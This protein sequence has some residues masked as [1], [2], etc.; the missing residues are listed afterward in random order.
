MKLALRS[1][2]PEYN[3]ILKDYKHRG[4]WKDPKN[5]RMF[6][7]KLA[8]KLNIKTPEDWYKV[9][10]KTFLKEGGHFLKGQYKYS[11][12][13]GK[14]LGDYIGDSRNHRLIPF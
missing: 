2:Y 1:V 3:A 10:Y 5:Q 14:A 4:Y 6:M 7:Q 11:L 13:Q 8:T 12:I 9:D